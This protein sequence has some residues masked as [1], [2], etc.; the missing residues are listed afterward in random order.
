MKLLQNFIAANKDL[1]HTILHEEI[2]SA[3]KGHVPS[4]SL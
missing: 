4:M 2:R 3:Q 1:V